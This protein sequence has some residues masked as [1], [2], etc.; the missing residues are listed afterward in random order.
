MQ[1]ITYLKQ[2]GMPLKDIQEYCRLCRLEETEEHLK[3]R[4]RIILRQRDAARKKAE[5]AQAA[6]AFIDHKVKHYEDILSHRI[7]DDT[8]P[9]QWADGVISR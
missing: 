7:P 2:C 8:N 9:G 6:A 5:E 1:A 4:Y 3:A